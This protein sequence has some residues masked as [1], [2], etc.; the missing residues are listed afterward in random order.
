M[1]TFPM[2]GIEIVLSE[3]NL[4]HLPVIWDNWPFVWKSSN[5]M[6]QCFLRK[7]CRERE[8]H[9]CGPPVDNNTTWLWWFG[10][11]WKCCYHHTPHSG[12]LGDLWI[13]FE[14]CIITL[15]VSHFQR[16]DNVCLNTFEGSAHK[17]WLRSLLMVFSSTEHEWMFIA[18]P[19]LIW[20]NNCNPLLVFTC[21]RLIR[22]LHLLTRFILKNEISTAGNIIPAYSRFC[23]STVS[24]ITQSEYVGL[25]AEVHLFSAFP[26]M[27]CYCAIF[28]R[29]NLLQ[30]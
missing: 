17:T 25:R 30:D 4:P 24:E 18:V 20:P 6:L 23:W 28:A 11:R 14:F 26:I 29:C 12:W 27:E 1:D 16:L 5:Y 10:I 3:L 13:Y 8:K 7:G 22:C 19:W 15:R 9:K 2:T 21:Y